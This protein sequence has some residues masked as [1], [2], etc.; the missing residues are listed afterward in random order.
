MITYELLSDSDSD[1][2]DYSLPLSEFTVNNGTL[3]ELKESVEQLMFKV[4]TYGTNGDTL[5]YSLYIDDVR[6]E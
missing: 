3:F 2:K 1:F 4:I 5:E 6:F